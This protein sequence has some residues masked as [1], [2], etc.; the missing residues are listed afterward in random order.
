[1]NSLT[2]SEI[3]ARRYANRPGYRFVAAREVGIAVFVMDLRV[4]VVEPKDLPPVDEFLLR[5]LGLEIDTPDELANFLGLDVR[6]VENRLVELRRVELIELISGAQPESVRCR[7]T[8]RGHAVTNTLHRA[9]LREVTLP[10]VVYHGFTRRTLLVP[11]EDLLRP[12]DLKDLGLAA[13]PPIPV[14]APRPEEI[15]LE[16]LAAV[17]RNQWHRKR[18]GKPPEIITVRSVLHGVRTMYYPAVML[19]YELVG[20]RG[21]KVVSFAIDGVLDEDVERAFAACKGPDR[22]PELIAEEFATT[23]E[24]A[25][26]F[27]PPHIAKRLGNLSDV[28]ELVEKLEA[29]DAKLVQQEAAPPQDPSRPDTKQVLRGEIEQLRQAKTELEAKLSQRKARRL[30]TSDC[31]ALLINTLSQVKE[32]LV[33]VSAF[34]S[35]KVVDRPF[36]DALAKALARGVKVWIAYGLEEHGDRGE[37]R[38]QSWDWTEAEEG[39]QR[40]ADQYPDTF[41]LANLGNTHEKILLRDTDFVVSGSFN[42][43]SFRADPRKKHRHEDALQVTEAAAIDEYFSEITSR[44]SGQKKK[45]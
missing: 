16:E 25:R 20:K 3:A 38:D 36:L 41:K 32:R 19:Q 11:E 24:L 26:E 7:L 10:R 18:K 29:T 12:R 28:D 39:L 44:F 27:V 42:W 33:I 8:S 9:E 15:R 31:R 14:R 35:S 23:A 6:T 13:I 30:R 34:L 1:M 43:L 2:T 4:I 22:I 21:H 17:I 5:S 40:V 45:A 37:R